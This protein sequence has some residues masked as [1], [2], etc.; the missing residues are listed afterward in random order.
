MHAI[1]ILLAIVPDPDEL[2]RGLFIGEY[3]AVVDA[4]PP[5]AITIRVANAAQLECES[6]SPNLCHSSGPKSFLSLPSSR[7]FSDVVASQGSE[8]AGG[9]P[10]RP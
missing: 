4:I 6:L 10:T 1:K 8:R 3:A 9:K 2:A 5:G 7:Q